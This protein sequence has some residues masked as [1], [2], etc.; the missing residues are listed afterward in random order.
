MSNRF[1]PAVI[2]ATVTIPMVALL[3]L[4]FVLPDGGHHLVHAD[5]GI[6]CSDPVTGD[7][8]EYLN[9]N[10]GPAGS[11]AQAFLS[12]SAEPLQEGQEVEVIFDPF[13]DGGYADGVL[14]A[15]GQIDAGQSSTT[16]DF[17]VPNLM[18]GYHDVAVCWY[19]GN[20]WN[21]VTDYFYIDPAPNC[22]N[23]GPSDAGLTANPTDPRAGENFEAD[24]TDL[25][26]EDGDRPVE[27]IL[28]FGASGVMLLD[29]TTIPSDSSSVSEPYLYTPYNTPPGS[30]TLT[31]CWQES[32]GGWTAVS[33]PLQVQHYSDCGYY[34][35][36][37]EYPDANI[38]ISPTDPGPDEQFHVDISNVP[39][40]MFGDQ[41]AELIWNW[42][43]QFDEGNALGNDDHAI[44][45]NMTAGGVDGY[46]PTDAQPGDVLTVCWF[47][48][49]AA[50][51]GDCQPEGTWYY[52]D[53]AYP[54]ATEP[55]CMTTQDLTEGVTPEDLANL[56]AGNG[57]AVSNVT[58]NG[59]SVSAGVFNDNCPVI[60]FD[61]GVVLSSGD[62]A[63][64]IG[65][66]TSDSV[67]GVNG[68]AGDADLNELSGF[69]TFDAAVLAFDFVPDT[70]LI[71][72]SYVFGSDEYNEYVNS[73]FNDV[74]AFYVNGN[75]C[76][77]VGDQP[78]TINTINGGNPFGS[79]PSSHPELYRNND[80]NDPAATL[81]TEMDGLTVVLTCEANVVP[82]ETNHIK[83]A[84]ADASD[85]NYD[86]DIFLRA[87][88]F[89][90]TT[91][92]AVPSGAVTPS[93]IVSGATETPVSTGGTSPRTPAPTRSPAPTPTPTEQP[94][95]V[96]PTEV[97]PTPVVTPT[98][99]PT[100]PPTEP[101]TA[102]PTVPPTP[103][104]TPVLT[105]HRRWAPG[106][107]HAVPDSDRHAN[108]RPRQRRSRRRPRRSSRPRRRRR[109]RRHH[110]RQRHR[111][112]HRRARRRLRFRRGR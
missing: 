87:G 68:T 46:L 47:H 15:D 105:P 70:S 97:P 11:S 12:L 36:V 71:R 14:V 28:D 35:E 31:A 4:A 33:I 111:P 22:M 58:Y 55:A 103:V 45:I 5:P 21:V 107:D 73:E 51:C 96:P 37:V 50:S 83:L 1:R 99:V 41:Y 100:L 89:V 79:E 44:P 57:V 91:P 23:P 52:K 85:S 74:F 63:N 72:F 82:G 29:E 75:N 61:S 95:E 40:D 27:F 42:S 30:H 69:S 56:L 25:T 10:E 60:G 26:P 92:T 93:P 17:V 67:T 81:E 64:V 49:D 18:G 77:T 101:P 59:A 16:L 48:S 24:L 13:N 2:A 104:V 84:I 86:S 98:E 39:A 76:A 9:P 3:V 109:R 112:R 106:D 20:E 90:A 38:G 94:T 65:P 66:N 34:N 88:S 110:R 19:D 32:S 8:Y 102:P 78:V 54:F 62:I 6:D 80:P 43:H 108:T 53:I 7:A